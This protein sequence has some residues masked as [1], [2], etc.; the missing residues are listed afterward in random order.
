MGQVLRHA[1]GHRP[2]G[3]EHRALGGV[4]HGVVRGVGGSRQRRAHE[5]R[6]D[7]LT[8]SRRQ[9]LGCAAHDLR[10]DHAAVP[11][12]AEKG[13]AGDGLDQVVAP[14]VV[15]RLPVDP[16]ELREH[17]AE[18]H[19]HVVARVAVGDREDVQVVDLL[20]PALE[21]GASLGDRPPE[22]DDAGVRHADVLHPLAEAVAPPGK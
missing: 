20:P 12:R 18:G 17:G 15:D 9:L 3:G 7:Q 4:P 16:V 21:L 11:A 22:A 10:E 19:R 6:I 5:D 13:G 14:Q 8:G 1:V 2:Y